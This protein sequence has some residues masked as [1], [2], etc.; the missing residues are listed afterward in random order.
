LRRAL[1]ESLG[2][3]AWKVLLWRPIPAVLSASAIVW[4]ALEYLPLAMVLALPSYF[5]LLWLTGTVT[6]RD[7]A[8]LQPLLPHRL[9]ERFRG[10]R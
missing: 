6:S 4:F 7:V 10:Y 9:V 1:E 8:L 2:P 3:I 5:A